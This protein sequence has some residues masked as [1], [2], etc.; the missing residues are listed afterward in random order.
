MSSWNPWHGCR[1]FSSGCLNCYVYRI[2]SKFGRDPSNF[3]L[4]SA[5]SLP[6]EKFRGGKNKDS[7]KLQPKDGIVYTCFSSDFFFEDADQHRL[8]AWNM[9]RRRP[10]LHFFIPTKRIHRIADCLPPDWGDGYENTTIACTAENQ[11]MADQ[12]LPLFI[13]LPIQQREIIVEPML[14]KMDISHYLSGIAHVTA[15]G[16]SGTDA[17]PCDLQWIVALQQ[18]CRRADVPFWF[19]QTGARFVNE[20]GI[21]VSVPRMNQQRLAANYRLDFKP[22][23]PP[24]LSN[25]HKEYLS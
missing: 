25:E 3:C 23:S 8:E 18:Q 10:D 22:I 20:K 15:G 6:L 5:F 16:E 14:E 17:R 7:Y 1:K 2:D 19:K 21:S 11:A 12:R 13:S 24:Y 4:T 9:I